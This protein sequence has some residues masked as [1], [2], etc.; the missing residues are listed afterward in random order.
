MPP[1]QSDA[2]PSLN[3]I[4]AQSSGAPCGASDGDCREVPDVSADAD[5]N[6]GYL[7][8]WDRDWG[9]IG[10]TSAAAPLWAALIALS[11]ASST[12]NGTPIGFLNPDLYE[13]AAA[14]YASSFNDITSGNNDITGTDGGLFRAGLRYDMASGLGTPDGSAL[15]AALCGGAGTPAN[16]V[17][18]TN[19]GDQASSP[20]IPISVQIAAID[21]SSGESLTYSATGLPAGL[22]IDS[23]TGLIS[24]TP[25][26]PGSSSVTITATDS[27]E[28]FGIVLFTWT[29]DATLTVDNPGNQTTTVGTSVQLQVTAADSGG[30]SLTYLASG[31]PAGLSLDRSTGVVSG[32]PTAVG[33]TGVNIVVSSTDDASGSTSFIWNVLAAP[34][35]PVVVAASVSLADPG[36]QSGTV[37]NPVDVQIHAGDSDGGGLSYAATGLPRGLTIAPASGLIS[38]APE[39]VGRSKVTVTATDASGPSATASFGWTIA[40]AASVSRGSLSGVGKGKAKLTFSVTARSGSAPI[41][42]V[43]IG[44]PKGLGFSSR[45][46]R[47]AQGIVLRDQ[48]GRRVS[49][50]ATVSHGGL[51]IELRSPRPSVAVTVSRVELSVSRS[52]RRRVAHRRVRSLVVVLDAIDSGKVATQFGLKLGV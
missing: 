17:T 52:L 29:V 35:S 3:V 1:Y 19:P 16:T 27:T 43:E 5:P 39:E 8:Y 49:F 18:V 40:T 26:T 15:P 24:G 6:T 7:I 10:G 30:G 23:S 4:N 37:G 34:T 46:T 28:S 9:A 41:A 32:S 12:C 51:T 47:L 44:L 36:D 42:T 48:S 45:A 14:A 21:S 2:M 22:S 25:T 50:T 38:G 33:I 20:G 13:A 11:N 31:L